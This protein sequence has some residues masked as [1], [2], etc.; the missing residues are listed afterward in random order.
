MSW[1][2][3]SGVDHEDDPDLARV[4]D[5]RDPRVGAVP[6][7]QPVEDLER[8]LDAHVLVG[9]GPAIEQDLRL[10]LVDQHV[11][12]DLGRPQL[13]PEV[14][15]PDGEAL[16]DGGMGGCD[17]RDLGTDLA[18]RVIPLE[19][20]RELARGERGG[21]REQRDDEQAKRERG[22]RDLGETAG[23]HGCMVTG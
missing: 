6:V 5:A 7:G 4:D 17:R 11:V 9:V 3:P 8:H 23:R 19:S 13:S 1:V 16:D 15:L 20:G 14:A 10:V 2:A 12:R 22:R 21:R 18:V